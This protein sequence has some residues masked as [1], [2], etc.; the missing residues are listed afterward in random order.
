VFSVSVIIYSNCHM[1][2]F[3]H[4]MF[5][6]FADGWRIQAGDATDHWRD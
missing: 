1:L 6:V 2:Q 4:Q 3:L 5:N